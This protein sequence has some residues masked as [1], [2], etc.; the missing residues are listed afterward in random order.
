MT[1]TAIL[2]CMLILKKLL[3]GVFFLVAYAVMVIIVEP[4]VYGESNIF[5]FDLGYLFRAIEVAIMLLFS[6]LLFA[7][8][9]ILAGE[10]IY[11]LA[12]SLIAAVIPMLLLPLNIG[13]VL[14][15]G[16]AV[17]LI[18][19]YALL[20]PQLKTYIN[21]SANQILGPSIK[22]LVMLVTIAISLVYFF[23]IRASIEQ[24]GFEIPDS[25]IDTALKLS[26]AD[27][28]VESVPQLPISQNQINELKKNPDLLKQYGLDPKILDT[29]NQPA[30]KAT[31][32]AN[33]IIKKTIK[34]QVAAMVKP[35]LGFVAPVM[36]I[37][38]YFTISTFT[39]LLMIFVYVFLW[40]IFYILEQTKF[41][42]FEKEMREV[43]KLV[44]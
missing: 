42:H 34:D 36:A 16:T 13:Y 15:I 23:N 38:F 10:W 9:A 25:L 33:D 12:V 30:K 32:A 18:I 4:L 1:T 39:S 40:L 8:F 26:P 44:I 5:G 6:A 27:V 29:L 35:Y 2:N 28:S 37:L 14:G 31:S 20:S 24:N 11:I 21:F 3:F 41:I 7:V 19:T 22:L 17:S 43:K